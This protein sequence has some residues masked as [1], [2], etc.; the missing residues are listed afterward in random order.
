[1]ATTKEIFRS[2]TQ[3]TYKNTFWLK[4]ELLDLW[5]NTITGEVRQYD[6]DKC[7]MLDRE[8]HCTCLVEK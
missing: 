8:C 5:A 4:L 6:S 7:Q 1:M 2:G 3:I